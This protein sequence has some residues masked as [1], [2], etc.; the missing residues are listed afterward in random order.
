MAAMIKPEL[1]NKAA[2]VIEA[3]NTEAVA[4]LLNAL[5]E[6]WECVLDVTALK[7]HDPHELIPLFERYAERQYN[8]YAENYC[9]TF[10]TWPCTPGI[11]RWT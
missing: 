4:E 3:A 6:Y 11:C 9:L 10:P 7:Q 8:A 5:S 1:S 2:A